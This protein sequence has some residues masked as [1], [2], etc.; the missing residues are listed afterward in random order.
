MKNRPDDISPDQ[1]A[2][3][4]SAPSNESAQGHIPTRKQTGVFIS[5]IGAYRKQSMLRWEGID[6]KD[7]AINKVEANG[8]EFW[9][10]AWEEPA[11]K[12][13]SI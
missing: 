4:V 10:V 7:I 13:D 11:P 5:S 2:L 8:D 6:A 12:S 1:H 9:E 3:E